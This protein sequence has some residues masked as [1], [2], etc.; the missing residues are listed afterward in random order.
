M[1]DLQNVC[2]R[3]G[4]R[5]DGAGETWAWLQS[6]IWNQS[7]SRSSRR[8]LPTEFKAS[9]FAAHSMCSVKRSI[10][11]VAGVSC[12]A[13]RIRGAGGCHPAPTCARSGSI[14]QSRFQNGGN[15]QTRSFTLQK[16]T[17]LS[18]EL[19]HPLSLVILEFSERQSPAS[20]CSVKWT[21]SMGPLRSVSYSSWILGRSDLLP[22]QIKLQIGE[23]T[24]RLHR[25]LTLSRRLFNLVSAVAVRNLLR[26]ATY[27]VRLVTASLALLSLN[28]FR[29]GLR[30]S[31][32]RSGSSPRACA[33]GRI[34]RTSFQISR[35]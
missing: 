4:L 18:T 5:A 14:S 28:P 33:L 29:Q 19:V 31:F 21:P 10:L 22:H 34:I 15:G 35:V 25:A 32:G 17:R 24:G 23:S 12:Q 13:A 27:R 16:A 6:P 8:N 2:G 9:C 1:P 26:R 7:S 3:G 11:S 20:Q 30:L